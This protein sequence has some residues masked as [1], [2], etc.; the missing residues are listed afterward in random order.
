MADEAIEFLRPQ[1][2]NIIL[3]AT[4]GCAGHA[5]KIL[6][7]ISP[8]GFLIGIDADQESLAIAGERLKRF[9]R[10][11]YSLSHGNFR[12]TEKI[13]KKLD[14]K[15]IDGALFDLGISSFQLEKPDRGFSF[16]RD[17]SLDMRMDS[18]NP[19]RAYDLVNRCKREDLEEIIK[20]FGEERFSRRI[21]GAIL[22]ERKTRP[23]KTT[24]ELADLITRSV[25]GR[26]RMQKIHP[27]TRTFQALRIAVNDELKSLEE[28]ITKIWDFL[29]PGARACFISFHSLEDRI[30]KRG[31]KELAKLERALILTK[32]PITPSEEEKAKNARA[33][34]A[35]MRVAEKK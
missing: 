28:V 21:A 20:T 18:S 34:S 35:K 6:E 7:K 14:I 11:S 26:Y 3:D 31:F 23:I 30:V 29:N 19:V 5:E 27:A 2:G 22:E 12:D 4:V 16:G 25:G 15:K 33:R 24:R 13:F 1:K 8:G 10:E 9:K 17:G 32:K